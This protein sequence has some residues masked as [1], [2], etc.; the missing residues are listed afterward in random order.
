MKR[1][2]LLQGSIPSSHGETIYLH[3][4]GNL[5]ISFYSI[6]LFLKNEEEE[7]FFSKSKHYQC[8]F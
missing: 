6:Q 7:A 8:L 3:A 4:V 5:F 2:Y 1:L